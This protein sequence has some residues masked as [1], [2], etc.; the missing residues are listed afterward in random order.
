[1]TLLSDGFFRYTISMRKGIILCIVVFLL[2]LVA[3]PAAAQH[4]PARSRASSSVGRHKT[5]SK[6]QSPKKRSGNKNKRTGATTSARSTPHSV[7]THT[8][9]S[10]TANHSAREEA[11]HRATVDQ[12][13]RSAEINRLERQVRNASPAQYPLRSIFRARPTE[14]GIDNEAFTGTFIQVVYQGK[15]EVYGVVATHALTEGGN[16]FSLQR[17]FIADVYIDGTFMEVPMEIVQLGATGVADVSLVKVPEEIIPFIEPYNLM[18][19]SAET[20]GPLTS[21]GF[22]D[23]ELKQVENRY[24]I[25]HR[26]SY[27][28]RTMMPVEPGSYI[29]GCGGPLEAVNENGVT[30]LAGI[31]TGSSNKVGYAT[32]TRFL[33]TLVTA[34]HNHGEGYFPL[35]ISGHHVMDLRADEYLSQI[36]F[37]DRKGNVLYTHQFE[38]KFSYTAVNQILQEYPVRALELTVARVSWQEN[39]PQLLKAYSKVRR[40][41]YDLRSEELTVLE[42][43]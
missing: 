35:E 24:V 23:N 1:M 26:S 8:T 20:A 15:T 36:A 2:G 22:V 38:E 7:S 37:L 11:V 4:H 33:N 32:S 30:V 34:Y 12:F 10:Y 27:S 41:K 13:R 19:P 16:D 43:F 28:M 5:P 42:E 3:L 31:H 6:K 40:V 9:P 25:G 18:E 29:G 21:F 17:L 14:P 39:N